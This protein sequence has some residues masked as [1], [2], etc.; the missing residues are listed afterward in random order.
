MRTRLLLSSLFLFS[1]FHSLS[2]AQLAALGDLN[3]DGKPDVVVSDGGTEGQIGVFL[4]TGN[5]SLGTGSF[6][7]VGGAS[8]SVWLADFNGDGHLDILAVTNPKLQI[9]FGDGKGGFAAPVAIPQSGIPAG[10]PSVVADFNGDGFADI[11]FAF[12]SPNP[13]V[14]VLFGDGHGGFSLSAPHLIAIESGT[15]TAPSA[16]FVVDAN[17]DGLPDLVINSSGPV[18]SG[19]AKSF[20]AINDG[21]GGFVTSQLSSDTPVQA[22]GDFNSDGNIDFFMP[23][24]NLTVIFGDGQGGILYS[25]SRRTCFNQPNDAQFG[26]DFDHNGTTDLVGFFGVNPGNGHG[27]FGDS[28]S[29][30]P[31]PINP[32]AVADFN[33]DGRPDLVLLVSTRPPTASILLNN[34]A[35]PV[36]IS[37]STNIRNVA[38]VFNTNGGQPVT[39]TA[40]M[41]SFCGVPTG[42]VTFTDGTTTLGSAPVN[43]YGVASMDTTF[44]TGGTHN[45][46]AAFTGTLDPATNTFYGNS[47]AP[48]FTVTANNAPPTAP[49]PVMVLN[50]SDNPAREQNPI[51]LT[52]SFTSPN[53]PTTGLVTFRADGQVLGVAPLFA[54]Q[55]D[56]PFPPGLHNLSV[57]FGGDGNF[58]PATS[59]TIV[60]D[61]R[62]FTAARIAGSVHLTV[63]PPSATSTSQSVALAATLV[64]VPNPQANFIYRINGAFIASAPITQSVSFLPPAQGTNTISAEY[65]GDAEILPST[66]FQIFV[67][68]NSAGDFQVS[69]S[70][71][72]ATIKAGQTATFTITIS[73]VNGM[74]ST[75]TFAC[76]GLPAASSCTFSPASVTPNGSPAST[77]LTISTTAASSLATPIARLRPWSFISWPLGIVFGFF[78]VGTAARRKNIKRCSAVFGVIALAFLVV[79]CGGGSPQPNPTTGTPPGTSSITVTAT[80]GTSHSSALT[81]TVTP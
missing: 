50:V 68:G 12:S 39:L 81:I 71:S 30:S 25:P 65:V 66:A 61:V 51:T 75:V 13:A 62:A 1:C 53:P 20:L 55:I 14:A 48:V 47:I 16:L 80:S 60:E 57:T 28:F 27:G 23:S 31:G 46:G 36:S 44:P 2:Y 9:L 37:A 35:T 24:Q 7:N 6:L 29:L 22:V 32:I 77:T 74:N 5:G 18:N 73:P 69:A 11:A 17:N 54:P 4:N 43:I 10:G 72:G 78:V 56:V 58:P 21:K 67:V 33:A 59:N 63:T 40:F 26:I 76:S 19:L 3:G 79:S 15:N 52:A 49:A 70:P 45:I 34:V 42:S 64:G 41:N 38:S 8:S